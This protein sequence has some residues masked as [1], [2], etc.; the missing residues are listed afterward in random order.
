MHEAGQW[1]LQ[2][3]NQ[4]PDQDLT[5]KNRKRQLIPITCYRTLGTVHTEYKMLSNKE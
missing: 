2:Y 3:V 1:A 5:D 4:R